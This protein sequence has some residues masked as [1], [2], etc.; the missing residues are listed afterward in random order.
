MEMSSVVGR[1]NVGKSHRQRYGA[2][3]Q[4]NNP[5][6]P[7]LQD[8]LIAVNQSN[9]CSTNRSSTIKDLKKLQKSH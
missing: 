9:I 7:S 4:P 8:K 6:V 5:M 2:S 3:G 1:L